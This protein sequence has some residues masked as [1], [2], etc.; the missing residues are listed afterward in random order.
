MDTALNLFR[1]Y[2]LGFISLEEYEKE[3][4]ELGTD[5]DTV[6]ELYN[7]TRRV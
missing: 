4:K 3:L 2:R 6:L 1:Y 7:S 5:Y